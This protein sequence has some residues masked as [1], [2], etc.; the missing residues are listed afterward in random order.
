MKNIFYPFIFTLL[1]IP[2]F[3]FAYNDTIPLN[4]RIFHDNIIKEQ[5]R[6]DR[7]DGKL[8]RYI[9]ISNIDEVNLQ[10]TDAIFRKVD[11]LRNS[12]EK[13]TALPTN[14]DK[15]RYL[16]FLESL[17][18]NFNNSWKSHKL[19][20]SLAP[21]LVDN[22]ASILKANIRGENMALYINQVPYQV[23][24]INT[25]I[26]KIIVLKS[27]CSFQQILETNHFMVKASF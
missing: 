17:V 11:N 12:I 23:G 26:F 7:L 24:A 25:E 21:V 10:V 9:K 4:R 16:R 19:S 1:T 3:S 13:N 22:F 18:R 27:T 20:P 5:Q 2:F 8:D 15:I 14:N 6:A